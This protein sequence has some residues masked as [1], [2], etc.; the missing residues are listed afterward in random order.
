M[1][2]VLS[3]DQIIYGLRCLLGGQRELA[4]AVDRAA[5]PDDRRRLIANLNRLELDMATGAGYAE[6]HLPPERLLEL[7]DLGFAIDSSDAET[8]TITFGSLLPEDVD[9]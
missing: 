3:P 2:D 1:S 9:V 6:M 5:D 4:D 7:A 8:T